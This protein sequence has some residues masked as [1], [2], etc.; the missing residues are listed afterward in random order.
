[1][2]PPAGLPLS[3]RERRRL[4]CGEM[5][6]FYQDFL[7]ADDMIA[8]CNYPVVGVE[9]CCHV[10]RCD[11][12]QAHMLLS[13]CDG[14]DLS[15]MQL[16]EILRLTFS[17]CCVC[18]ASVN[19]IQGWVTDFTCKSRTMHAL[20]SGGDVTSAVILTPYN[21]QVRRIRRM[22]KDRPELSQ[23]GCPLV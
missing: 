22:L 10:S 21:G 6:A 5:H 23:V 3:T 20:L 18:P 2:T 17:H 4:R 15:H 1:M 11:S 7:Q 8:T 16:L 14:R 9:L 12:Q 13:L 19:V